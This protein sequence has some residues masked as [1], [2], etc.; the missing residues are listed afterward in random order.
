MGIKDEFCLADKKYEEKRLAELR[1]LKFI[2]TGK[3]VYRVFN[4][5]TGRFH[6]PELG[7]DEV[8]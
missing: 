5:E 8:S 2:Q 4:P 1:K 3:N 6:N 7:I